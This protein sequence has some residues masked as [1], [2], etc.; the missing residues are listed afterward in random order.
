MFNAY[1][2]AVAGSLAARLGSPA[3]GGRGSRSGSCESLGSQV[4]DIMR[5]LLLVES[6][7]PFR[8]RNLFVMANALSIA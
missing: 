1:L 7:A 2:A 6:P 4:R 8:E 5:A 3:L